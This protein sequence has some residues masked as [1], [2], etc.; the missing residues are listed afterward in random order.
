M[1]LFCVCDS[2]VRAVFLCVCVC[3]RMWP[4]GSEHKELDDSNPRFLSFSKAPTADAF[5]RAYRST[6]ATQQQ[7]YNSSGPRYNTSKSLIGSSHTYKTPVFSP[8]NPRHPWI[9]SQPHP[10]GEPRKVYVLNSYSYTAF[11]TRYVDI[12]TISID[13]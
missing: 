12:C 11:H 8:F 5:L 9:S 4:R 3:V 6:R 7:E 10:E 2:Y 1:K 13:L